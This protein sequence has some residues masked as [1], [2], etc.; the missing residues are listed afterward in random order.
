MNGSATLSMRI[1]DMQP[2]LDVHAFQR[3]LQGQAVHHGGEHAHVVGG[4]RLDALA[5]GGELRPAEEVAAADHDGEL[6]PA[7]DDP[8]ELLGDGQRLV[9]A[10]AALSPPWPNASPLSFSRTRLYFGAG[11]SVSFGMSV[12]GRVRVAPARRARVGSRQSTNRARSVR[13]ADVH[14][15]AEAR[16]GADRE[17][18]KPS[19]IPV[20]MNPA[21]IRSSKRL[22]GEQE[23]EAPERQEHEAE[24]RA[25]ALVQPR[26]LVPDLGAALVLFR[27][28]L[29][30]RC[31]RPRSSSCRRRTSSGRRR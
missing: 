25:V 24:H 30:G 29:A 28:L 11:G 22:F 21:M 7:R 8:L 5:A 23:A 26:P 13:L 20:R 4:G 31:T 18:N 3:V 6:H 16:P 1:A 2:R 27:F 10:D 19:T 14:A 12:C 9:E 15:G 17:L